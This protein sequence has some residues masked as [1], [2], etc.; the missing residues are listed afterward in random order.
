[1]RQFK[2]TDRLSE[3]IRRYT[4]EVVDTDYR[5]IMPAM[6]TFTSVRLSRDLRYATIYYS[7]LGDESMKESVYE[8]LD[9]SKKHIRSAVGSNMHVRRIPEF[10]FKFDPSVEEGMKIERLLNEIKSDRSE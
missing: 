7:F 5:G 8:F 2:R 4:S 1:M 10:T 3:Q 9:R 6:I